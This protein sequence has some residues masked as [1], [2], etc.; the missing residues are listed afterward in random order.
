M[1]ILIV[2]IDSGVDGCAAAMDEDGK[3]RK[4]VSLFFTDVGKGM[5]KAGKKKTNKIPDEYKIGRTVRR[6]VKYAEKRNADLIIYLE[7]QQVFK[8]QGIVSSGKT[9]QGYG[10]W[11]GA[12]AAQKVRYATVHSKTW[13][14]VMMMDAKGTDTKARSLNVARRLFPKV[15]LHLVKDHNKS[16]ALLIAEYV[17]RK[18]IKGEDV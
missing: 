9:M 10:M 16:D 3:V 14:K 2:G 11:L 4:M 12:L 7:K 8:G 6:M 18:L 17:R 1:R 13:G 15:D 5:T